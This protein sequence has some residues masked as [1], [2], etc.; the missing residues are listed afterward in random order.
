MRVAALQ[1]PFCR[2]PDIRMIVTFQLGENFAKRHRNGD[3]GAVVR[4]HMAFRLDRDTQRR[5]AGSHQGHQRVTTRFLGPGRLR[6]CVAI[7]VPKQ[8]VNIRIVAL[9]VGPPIKQMF[10]EDRMEI[11]DRGR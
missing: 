1:L 2:R 8:L 9:D 5:E 11:G 4:H 10:D 6:P 7:D 3:V